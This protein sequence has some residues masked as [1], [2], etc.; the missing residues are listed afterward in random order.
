MAQVPRLT[1]PSVAPVVTPDIRATPEQFGAI[2]AQQ[3]TAFGQAVGAAADAMHAIQ[4]KIDT[5]AVLTAETKMKDAAT[6]A[7]QAFLSRRGVNAKDSTKD[8]EKVWNDT[9]NSLTDGLDNARQ[10]AVFKQ[11]VMPIHSA[12][13]ETISGH[14][15]Q[16]LTVAQ[17]NAAKA[18]IVSSINFAANN[19]NNPT[20]IGQ[21]RKN[22]ESTVAM[23]SHA[24][25]DTPEMAKL[26]KDQAISDMHTAVIENMADANPAGAMAYYKYFKDEISGDKKPQLEK[27]LA[28]ENAKALAQSFGDA[29]MLKYPHDQAAAMK[30]LRS[31]FSDPIERAAAEQE[32]NSRYAEAD[33]IESRASLDAFNQLDKVVLDHGITRMSMLDQKLL[34]KLKP[35]QLKKLRQD[36]GLQVLPVG[37]AWI[38]YNKQLSLATNQETQMQWAQNTDLGSTPDLT[39]DQRERLRSMQTAILTKAPPEVATTEQLLAASYKALGLYDLDKNEHHAMMAGELANYVYRNIEAEQAAH[40][41]RKLTVKEKQDII[42]TAVIRGVRERSTAGGF[43]HWNDNEAFLFDMTAEDIKNFTPDQIPASLR[44]NIVSVIQAARPGIRY[45]SARCIPHNDDPQTEQ[46]RNSACQM[47]IRRK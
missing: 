47:I 41:G 12:Y 27:A 3:E 33:A 15:V 46:T 29:M 20:A 13:A 21:A 40:N 9:V 37:P 14:E 11:R 22:I 16:Q 43:L 7:Q 34:L 39:A 17:D 4:D 28:A 10:K 30:E 6:Q 2:K 44:S 42:D 1:A 8:A 36:M 45:G 19:T 25:G 24:N 18:N 5:T 35:D 38:N 32:V 23:Q 26:R 31:K